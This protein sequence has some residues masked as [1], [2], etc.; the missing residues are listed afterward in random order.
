MPSRT[1]L[2]LPEDVMKR[3]QVL[4]EDGVSDE[5]HVKEKLK[6]VQ[7]F[8]HVD[9]QDQLT[10]LEEKMK[11]SEMSMEVYISKVKAL[12]GKELNLENGAHADSL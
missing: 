6:L 12:L 9:A 3:L 2:S 1:S 11:S 4:D 5:D 8:L 10:S 7:D